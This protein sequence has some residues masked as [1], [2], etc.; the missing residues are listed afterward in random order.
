MDNKLTELMNNMR[1]QFGIPKG[2]GELPKAG[3][4]GADV[5]GLGIQQQNGWAHG[6]IRPGCWEPISPPASPAPPP[7]VSG[8]KEKVLNPP[9]NGL[10]F[11]E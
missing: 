9:S 4:D 7:H 11:Q 2:T 3:P 1:T 8:S 5:A 10:D 6:S